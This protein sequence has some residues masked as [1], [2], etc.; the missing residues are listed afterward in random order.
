MYFKN[1]CLQQGETAVQKDTIQKHT[2]QKDKIQKGNKGRYR[3]D[4]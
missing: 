2:I 4:M 1:L 3:K